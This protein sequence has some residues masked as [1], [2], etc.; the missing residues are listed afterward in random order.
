MVDRPSTHY[1]PTSSS[2]YVYNRMCIS[3]DT[4]VCYNIGW[5]PRYS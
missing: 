4:S 3:L 1:F 2:S 5:Q